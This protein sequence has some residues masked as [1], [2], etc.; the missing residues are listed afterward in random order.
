MK[1]SFG[2]SNFLEEISSVSHFIVSLYFF[3]YCFPLS[4]S[5]ISLHVAS[6]TLREKLVMRESRIHNDLMIFKY[7][8]KKYKVVLH[9]CF[10][11]HVKSKQNSFL[12]NF[13]SNHREYLQ[14]KVQGK[15]AYNNK[16]FQT[17]EKVS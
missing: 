15:Y 12:K 1:G 4:L 8:T 14:R 5:F 16:K 6:L 10:Q 3:A 2:I 13:N 17:S 9:Q 7:P 11:V